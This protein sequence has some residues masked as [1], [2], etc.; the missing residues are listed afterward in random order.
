M[1]NTEDI[2]K[3][4]EEFY[5]VGKDAVGVNYKNGWYVGN[6]ELTTE[7]ACE[8]LF[9]KNLV[10]ATVNF[11]FCCELLLKAMLNNGVTIKGHNLAKLYGQLDLKWKKFLLI[12]MKYEND[13]IEFLSSL[14]EISNSFKKWRYIYEYSDEEKSIYFSFLNDWCITLMCAA[15]AKYYYE[16]QEFDKINQTDLELINSIN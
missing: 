5:N 2:I 14:N 12:K 11:S 3:Q 6:R 1:I 13:E 8:F 9:P 16:K 15:H 10:I 4:A 7:E